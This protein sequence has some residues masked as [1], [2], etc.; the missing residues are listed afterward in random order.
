MIFIKIFLI[1]ILLVSCQDNDTL[2]QITFNK[3]VKLKFRIEGAINKPGTYLI[4]KGKYINDFIL[5][6]GGYKKGAIKPDNIKIRNN[7]QIFINTNK[8]RN[9]INI[10]NASTSDLTKI[11]GIGKKTAHKILEYRSKHGAFKSITDIMK[12]KGIKEKLFNK[13]Y[14]YLII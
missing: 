6:N 14:E 8:I 11:K 3:E 1:I 13:I 4:D 5:S 7:L 2:K 12:V 9:K 10:N